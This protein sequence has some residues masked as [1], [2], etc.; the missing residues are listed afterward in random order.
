MKESKII[1]YL[2]KRLSKEENRLISERIAIDTTFAKKIQAIHEER[3]LIQLVGRNKIKQK[4]KNL[5]KNGLTVSKKASKIKVPLHNDND[6]FIEKIKKWDEKLVKENIKIDPPKIRPLWSKRIVGL[7]IAA[8]FLLLIG[9]FRFNTASYPNELIYKYKEDITGNLR[10]VTVAFDKKDY[11][12]I[13]KEGNQLLATRKGID[14]I[15]LHILMAN[16]YHKLTDYPKAIEQLKNVV[17]LASNSI[18][19]KAHLNIVTLYLKNDQ[20]K[21]ALNYIKKIENK[22]RFGDEYIKELTKLENK[23]KSILKNNK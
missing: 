20:P 3:M 16:T 17:A 7:S 4:M 18:Q 10:S 12:T 19:I 9:V 21:E 15:H 22:D 1:A 23:L 6:P 14:S 5:D 2:E 13:I 8:S 11:Q